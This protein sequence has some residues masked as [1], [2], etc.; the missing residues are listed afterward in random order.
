M[1]TSGSGTQM[2]YT[3]A[4]LMAF[5][6]GEL[7][8]D[9]AARVVEEMEHNPEVA[10]RVAAF[11]AS[12]LAVQRA[13]P[14]EPPSDDLVARIRAVASAA[15]ER[16]A[17]APSGSRREAE[18]PDEKIV[19]LVLPRRLPIWQLPLAAGIALTVGLS[20]S[21][22]RQ[23]EGGPAGLD[24]ALADAAGLTDALA[25]AASGEE[26]S[27]PGG[28]L[29]LIASFEAG[30]GAICREFEFHGQNEQTVISVAC[31]QDQDWEL[32]F[33]VAAAPADDGYAPAS[34][35]ESLDAWL[36]AIEASAPLSLEEE[37]KALAGA[38]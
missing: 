17:A 35:L 4:T 27:L 1:V 33:A 14:V 21:L 9:A 30:D 26:I 8:P 13:F 19:P 32:R 22:L 6:D 28:D 20:F 12:R 3:D 25:D 18:H 29:S 23:E 5:A 15:R 36:M 31:R 7:S 37:A 24:F 11:Q 16:E 2:T 10:A 38:N 34:S